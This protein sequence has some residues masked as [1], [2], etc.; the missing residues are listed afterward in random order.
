M[1][2]AAAELDVDIDGSDVHEEAEAGLQLLG[3]VEAHPRLLVL[4]STMLTE[5]SVQ[6]DILFQFEERG[7]SVGCPQW[8]V[9]PAALT[10]DSLMHDEEKEQGGRIFLWPTG[11]TGKADIFGGSRRSRLRSC[12][13]RINK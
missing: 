3:S 12:C 5:R 9:V 13:R 10:L 4:P 2:D 11:E 8:P 1:A 6:N 7:M